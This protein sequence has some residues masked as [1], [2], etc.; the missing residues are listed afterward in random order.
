M[1]DGL[2]SM[3][4]MVNSNCPHFLSVEV[5]E[6]SF[7]GEEGMRKNSVRTVEKVLVAM[8]SRFPG[9]LEHWGVPKSAME[10]QPRVVRPHLKRGRKVE[11]DLVF[12]QIEWIY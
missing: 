8:A 5:N 2:G 9:N 4:T 1:L 10:A 3:H 7:L 6:S 11:V 12:R